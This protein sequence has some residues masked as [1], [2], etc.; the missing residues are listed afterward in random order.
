[1]AL[2]FKNHPE[3]NYTVDQVLVRTHDSQKSSLEEAKTAILA[4]HG[5]TEL[6]Q[7]DNLEYRGGGNLYVFK[8]IYESSHPKFNE[9]HKERRLKAQSTEQ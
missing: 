2:A 1:M 8:L 5:A 7:L 9:Y 3:Q 4:A 6:V